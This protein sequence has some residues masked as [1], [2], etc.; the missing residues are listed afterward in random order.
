MLG[1]SPS[2]RQPRLWFRGYRG[3]GRDRLLAE[4]VGELLTGENAGWVGGGQ[5]AGRV[6]GTSR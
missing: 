4:R 1:G 5:A 2:G 6:P 3:E